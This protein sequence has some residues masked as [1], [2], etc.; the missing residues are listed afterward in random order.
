MAREQLADRSMTRDEA[1]REKA[2]L[3]LD[4][5]AV[6]RLLEEEA[7][8]LLAEGVRNNRS[9]DE[10]IAAIEELFNV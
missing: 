5:I 2:S 10:I 4:L 3:E 9:P 1:N 6:F 8:D 7:M